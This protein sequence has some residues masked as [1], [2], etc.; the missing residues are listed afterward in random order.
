MPSTKISGRQAIQ[1]VLADG[2]PRKAKAIVTAA[3]EIATGL[4]GKT[5]EA[6][7]SAMLYVEAKKA[8]G[9]VVRT[10]NKGEF[11]LRPQRKARVKA[12]PA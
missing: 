6:T 4:K 7:L 11:K 12:T 3:A 5:P 9:I 10:K 8:D 1:Q 2:K